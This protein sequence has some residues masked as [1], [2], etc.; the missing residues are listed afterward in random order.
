MRLPR[1]PSRVQ[2]LWLIAAVL[3]VGLLLALAFR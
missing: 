2:V 1:R 3:A